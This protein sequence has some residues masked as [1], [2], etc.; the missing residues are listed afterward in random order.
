MTSQRLQSR[1]IVIG[2]WVTT[3]AASCGFVAMVLIA[4]GHVRDGNGA[5]TF[6]TIWMVEDNWIGFLT[7]TAVLTFMLVIGLIFRIKEQRK[8]KREL[9]ALQAKYCDKS[10]E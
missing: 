10:T 2:L 6:R 8:E 7:F 1:L 4:I 5:D 9:E 3:I